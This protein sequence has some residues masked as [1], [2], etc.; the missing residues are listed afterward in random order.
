MKPKFELKELL[1]IGFTVVVLG[2]GVAY[3]LD[4]A[5]DVADDMCDGGTDH[6]HEG[7]CY[8]CNGTNNT[9]NLAYTLL[10][11]RAKRKHFHG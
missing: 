10:K 3:G 4:V 2:I 1:G 11:W 9:F 7:T 5:T 6:L 8:S